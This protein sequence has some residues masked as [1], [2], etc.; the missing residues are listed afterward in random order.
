MSPECL[1]RCVPRV[2]SRL[3]HLD[4]MEYMQSSSDHSSTSTSASGG[5]QHGVGDD[6][7]TQAAT[8]SELAA[9]HGVRTQY[10]GFDGGQTTVPEA[11]L[12]QVL[13]ALG[14]DVTTEGAARDSLRRRS[15]QPWRALLP[16]V[17]VATEAVP[18]QIPVHVSPGSEVTV[19]IV[20]DGAPRK[21]SR[22]MGD[23]ETREIDGAPVQRLLFELPTDLEPEWY[24]L[25]ASSV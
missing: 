15:E 6:G 20:V 22:A 1:S 2:L 4:S 12:R 13:T 8:L 7:A 10:D 18:T 9:A 14:A 19:E 23:G 17:V 16:P 24:Q 5:A 11:T 25:H 3:R 21:L